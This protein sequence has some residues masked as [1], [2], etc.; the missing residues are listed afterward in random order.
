MRKAGWSGSSGSWQKHW[1]DGK[2][3]L[4]RYEGKQVGLEYDEW[5]EWKDW[6]DEKKGEAE[7]LN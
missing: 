2:G 3:E 1:R 7:K 5:R 6:V 4:V